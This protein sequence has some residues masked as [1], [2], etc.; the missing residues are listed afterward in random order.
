MHIR[1]MRTAL[2]EHLAGRSEL[3]VPA[4]VGRGAAG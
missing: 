3:A 2:D 4:V 1:A